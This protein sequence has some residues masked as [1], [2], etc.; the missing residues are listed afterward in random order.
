MS[1]SASRARIDAFDAAI[2]ETGHLFGLEQLRLM[3]EDP[4][5]FDKFQ[6]RLFAAVKGIGIWIS[7]N[8]Q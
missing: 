8:L 4:T 6:W 3:D 2:R 1:T 7:S 5:Q